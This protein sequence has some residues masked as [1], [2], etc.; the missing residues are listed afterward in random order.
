MFSLEK[1]R[2]GRDIIALCIYL[3]GGCGKVGVGLP[4]NSGK[5]RRN[6]LKLHQGKFRLDVRKGF[7]K[8]VVRSWNGLTREVTPGHLGHLPGG[9]QEMC[10]YGTKE[11]VLVSS[12]GGRWADGLVDLRDLF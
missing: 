3:K 1:R 4:G 6:G 11:H 2:L 5:T 9:V 7:T 10:R 8:G 12:V